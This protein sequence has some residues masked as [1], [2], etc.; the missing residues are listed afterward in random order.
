LQQTG[1]T[2]GFCEKNISANQWDQLFFA[3]NIVTVRPDIF[4]KNIA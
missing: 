3:K 4:A 2:R 1:E